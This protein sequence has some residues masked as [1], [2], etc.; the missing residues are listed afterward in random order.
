MSNSG[1]ELGHKPMTE[2]AGPQFMVPGLSSI[3]GEK[4]D[5]EVKSLQGLAEECGDQLFF[6][7]KA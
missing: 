5:K 6:P 3:G 1:S 7:T 4:T 2:A